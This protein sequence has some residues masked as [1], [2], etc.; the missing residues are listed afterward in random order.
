MRPAREK[1]SFAEAVLLL[2]LGVLLLMVILTA[3]N[4]DKSNRTFGSVDPPTVLG[5]WE[6]TL[7]TISRTPSDTVSSQVMTT[8]FTFDDTTFTY[9]HFNDW[10]QVLQPYEGT[11][12]YDLTSTTIYLHPTLTEADSV[13][14]DPMLMPY[15]QGPYDLTLE[16]QRMV[17]NR[18]EEY[19]GGTE[20]EQLI[21]LHRVH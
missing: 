10:G 20:Q 17:L 4:N 11:A 18:L 15:R 2:V 16:H 9:Y 6:G 1:S 5:E 8:H 14:Y 7:V 19:L 13:T 21:D 3:C 12:G